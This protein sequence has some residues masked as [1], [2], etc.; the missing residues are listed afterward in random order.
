MTDHELN[1]KA[2]EAMGWIRQENNRH[3]WVPEEQSWDVIDSAEVRHYVADPMERGSWTWREWTP[4][5]DLNQAF[6]LCAHHADLFKSGELAI[7]CMHVNQ[8]RRSA[9][10]VAREWTIECLRRKGLLE[11]NPNVR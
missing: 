7:D 1:V 9:A 2:A 11:E 10:S 4:I 3:P 5:T 8:E 6:E